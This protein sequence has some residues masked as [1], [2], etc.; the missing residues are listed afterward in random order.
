MEKEAV[1]TKEVVEQ[2]SEAQIEESMKHGYAVLDS[3]LTNALDEKYSEGYIDGFNKGFK[4]GTL[5]FVALGV[6]I[7][8]RVLHDHIKNKK[9]GKK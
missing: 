8:I 4:Y 1:M 9:D 5:F 6:G 7:G 3:V 2:L